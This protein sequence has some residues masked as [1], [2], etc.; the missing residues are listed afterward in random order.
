MKKILSV[1]LILTLTSPLFLPIEK[2]LAQVNQE[3]QSELIAQRRRGGGRSGG[4][5]RSGGANRSNTNRGQNVNRSQMGTNGSGRVNKPQTRTNNV[6]RANTNNVNRANTNRTNTNN[7]LNRTNTNRTNTNNINRDINRTNNNINRDV[8]RNVNR[9]VNRNIDRSIDR[10]YTNRVNRNIVNTGDRNVVVNPRND[11]NN[12]GWNGNR[13]WY[14]NYNYWGGGFWG[15]VAAGAI[16]S[17]IV[18]SNDD[19]DNYSQPTYI[20]IEQNSPGFQM[21]NSYG[22][23]QVQCIEDGTQVYIYGPQN[24]LICARPNSLVSPGYYD[25]DPEGLI[26][27]AR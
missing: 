6:N 24:T 27:I 12:W 9:D 10:D 19:D 18:N 21:F 23:T 5:N 20:V 17:A 26:L 3:Q 7:N 2:V 8:N 4:G 14:P 22:L 1:S 13:P 15:G 11:W 16:T 25:V